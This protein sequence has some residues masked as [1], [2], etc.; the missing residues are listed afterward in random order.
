MDLAIEFVKT[1]ARMNRHAAA[2]KGTVPP[3]SRKAHWNK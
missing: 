2:Q 1:T 3:L